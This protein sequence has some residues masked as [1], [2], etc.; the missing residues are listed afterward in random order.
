MQQMDR[1]SGIDARYD[2]R[3]PDFTG[4]LAI[5]LQW[6]HPWRTFSIR[7]H[8]PG[9]SLT[10]LTKRLDARGDQ[11]RA[12][13]Q[14]YLAEPRR[15]GDLLCVAVVIT[16]DLLRYAREHL[17][18]LE[19]R[20]NPAMDNGGHV[21]FPFVR[22]SDLQTAGYKL[23][24]IESSNAT[25]LVITTSSPLDNR[26]VWLERPFTSPWDEMSPEEFEKA[27]DPYGA[28]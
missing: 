23:I 12:T 25:E 6:G 19:W 3:R 13:L 8:R 18:E 17:D 4:S 24:V 14:A 26:I 20:T 15:Q 28:R 16:D 27:G 5:R 11:P 21:T 22:W 9:D 7:G 10:E 1:K 2:T